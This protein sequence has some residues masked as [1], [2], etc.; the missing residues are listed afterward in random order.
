MSEAILTSV[1]AALLFAVVFSLI[2][3]DFP[4]GILS[5]FVMLVVPAVFSAFVCRRLLGAVG[6]LPA[7]VPAVG[8]P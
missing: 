7:H 4:G 1:A 6:I 8:L 3:Q 5:A 2:A